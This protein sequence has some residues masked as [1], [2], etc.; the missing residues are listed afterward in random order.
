MLDEKLFA[1]CFKDVYKEY[2][3]S[4]IGPGRYFDFVHDIMKLYLEGGPQNPAPVPVESVPYH[5][6][7]SPL[8]RVIAAFGA[9]NAKLWV[10]GRHMGVDLTASNQPPVYAVTAGAV[11]E[12]GYFRPGTTVAYTGGYGRR[13]IVQ[14]DG[15]Q[16]LY[17]HL[18]GNG[19]DLE[20]PFNTGDTVQAGQ[21]LGHMGGNVA[22]VYRGV[23]GG[24]HLHFEVILATQPDGIDSVKTSR[25]WCVD[26]LPWLARHLLPPPIATGTVLDKNG[27]NVRALP[28]AIAEKVGTMV[29]RE[30]LE[31][32]ELLIVDDKNTWARLRSLRTE[33]CAV[34]YQGKKLIEVVAL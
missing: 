20:I 22:D 33:W 16:T 7:T 21:I 11:I 27:S 9:K 17:A 4:V 8:A 25:G 28:S 32:A 18:R 31:I 5:Y 26:P 29:H 15:Y 3:S 10:G 12:A 23:S 14:H 6:P 24:P 19:P 30:Q 34:K 2:G 1:E 13:L